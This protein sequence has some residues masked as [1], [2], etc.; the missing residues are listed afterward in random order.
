MFALAASVKAQMDS[1]AKDP[2]AIR[3]KATEDTQP[4]EKKLRE[5]M[6][7]AGFTQQQIDTG[8]KNDRKTYLEEFVASS[9]KPAS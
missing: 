4:E 8:I 5:A 2:A 3:K 6:K 7:D 9:S 1:G